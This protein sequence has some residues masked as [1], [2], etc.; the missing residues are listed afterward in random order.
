MKYAGSSDDA[1]SLSTESMDYTT[2]AGG[3]HDDTGDML[4]TD[5]LAVDAERCCME[6]AGQYGRPTR[7]QGACRCFR[8]A[9]ALVEL[10]SDI[11]ALDGFG[12]SLLWGASAL[13]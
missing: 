12:M 13:D 1:A 3:A 9:S 4:F 6:T 10:A 7:A 8:A 11:R 5:A 2:S